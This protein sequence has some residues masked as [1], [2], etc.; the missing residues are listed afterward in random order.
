MAR[1]DVR[2]LTETKTVRVPYGRAFFYSNASPVEIVR[3]L[4][5]SYSYSEPYLTKILPQSWQLATAPV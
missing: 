1:F 5:T 2:Q 4:V 3:R